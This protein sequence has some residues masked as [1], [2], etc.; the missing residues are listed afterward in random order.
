MPMFASRGAYVGKPLHLGDQN[1][2]RA[3]LESGTKVLPAFG[4]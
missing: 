1:E 4:S 3:A 2:G